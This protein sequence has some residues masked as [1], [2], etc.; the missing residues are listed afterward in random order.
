MCDRVRAGATKAKDGTDVASSVRIR[1]SRSAQFFGNSR[2]DP[3]AGDGLEL[4]GAHASNGLD[5]RGRLELLSAT[6]RHLG[7]EFGEPGASCSPPRQ[8]RPEHREPALF[9][10]GW[11]GAPDAPAVSECGESLPAAKGRA[12]AGSDSHRVKGDEA[13]P[14]ERQ[15]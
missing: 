4:I 12:P 9:A 14:V 13:V 1:F 11:R 2:I 6:P 8:E 3:L 15:A 5:D 10:G 7:H